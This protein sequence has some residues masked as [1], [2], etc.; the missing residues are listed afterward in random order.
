VVLGALS[1]LKLNKIFLK[2]RRK[3]CG[4]R[5]I[6]EG[7]SNLEAKKGGSKTNIKSRKKGG[8]RI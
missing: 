3:R 8:K 5:K 2:S 4:S 7:V 1:G 6:K